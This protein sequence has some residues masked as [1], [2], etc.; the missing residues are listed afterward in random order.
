MD[1]PSDATPWT[2]EH[3]LGGV[4]QAARYADLIQVAF[5]AYAICHPEHKKGDVVRW[6]V[7]ISQDVSRKP[8]GPRVQTIGQRSMPY[9][10]ALD[11][12]LTAQDTSVD[13]ACPCSR[14]CG[15]S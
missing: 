6:V 13:L 5:W 3:D 1:M 11:R 8:F 15:V 4:P 10:F 14:Q 12:V 9:F 7:D 2:R